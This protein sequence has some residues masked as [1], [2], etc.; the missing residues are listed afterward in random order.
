MSEQKILLPNVEIKDIN[1]NS[2]FIIEDNSVLH[3]ATIDSLNKNLDYN[4]LQNHLGYNLAEL[5]SVNNPIVEDHVIAIEFDPETIAEITQK[6]NI[7]YTN[8]TF[9]LT[10]N[11]NIN[12]EFQF[13]LVQGIEGGI[14]DG[15]LL[16]A[17]D[18][19]S[20]FILIMN[21]ILQLALFNISNI[22][23][24]KISKIINI[25]KIPTTLIDETKLET[26]TFNIAQSNS[27][28][29]NLSTITGK[30]KLYCDGIEYND[31]QIQTLYTTSEGDIVKIYY[32]GE[33]E[34]LYNNGSWQ[35]DLPVLL[36][37]S[38]A[39]LG[40]STLILTENV[41][42]L[43]LSYNTTTIDKNYI[44][45]L[46]FSSSISEISTECDVIDKYLQQGYNV[47]LLNGER[48]VYAHG[49]TTFQEYTHLVTSGPTNFS[50]YELGL[51]GNLP[52]GMNV[53]EPTKTLII[54]PNSI[55][56][57]R[58]DNSDI[59]YTISKTP[60]IEND[61]LTF[62]FTEDIWDSIITWISVSGSLTVGNIQYKG[63]FTDQNEQ[64]YS[65]LFSF[66]G[67][68]SYINEIK[69]NFIDFIVILKE[70]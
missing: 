53:V 5:I 55:Q 66:K 33:I 8:D 59:A 52:H 7:N 41:S 16:Y 44:S 3:R 63:I 62:K 32:I 20:I 12:I 64:I 31:Y 11:D 6:Y 61:I 27:I 22:Y 38:S 48:V 17:N 30:I 47:E 24:F 4:K 46:D 39:F 28:N 25:N 60:I 70:E 68:G 37:S 9:L 14:P 1:N 19:F 40:G 43:K 18:D 56:L 67:N 34:N 65:T 35:G 58:Y 13:G 15:S 42:I 36:I 2:K 57:S 49:D 45:N 10:V 51:M 23:N 69:I 21:N 54:T 26:S 29:L 50:F